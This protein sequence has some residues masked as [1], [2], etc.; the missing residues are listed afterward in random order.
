MKF[1]THQEIDDH[2]RKKG[3]DVDKL[4]QEESQVGDCLDI[5]IKKVRGRWGFLKRLFTP[6]YGPGL[7][8]MN[9]EIEAEFNKLTKEYYNE[10]PI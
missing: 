3:V 7:G 10:H 6:I 4:K 8:N 9:S 1:K 5:A 2:Y